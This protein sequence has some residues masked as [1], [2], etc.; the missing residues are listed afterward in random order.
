MAKREST[1]DDFLLFAMY[2]LR[3]TTFNSSE[4]LIDSRGSQWNQASALPCRLDGN[5]RHINTVAAL[6]ALQVT[7]FPNSGFCIGMAMHHADLD[8]QTTTRFQ[9]L[10]ATICRSG[11]SSLLPAECLPIYDRADEIKNKKV[12]FIFTVDSRARLD[13]PIPATYFSNCVTG[14][15]VTAETCKI[16]GEDGVAIAVESF[17][18]AI[19]G[20]DSG[21]MRGMKKASH[22]TEPEWL[23]GIAGSTRFGVYDIDF[24]WGRPTK[25]ETS[26]I[27]KTGS[28]SLAESRDGSKGVETSSHERRRLDAILQKIPTGHHLTVL[29]QL[30]IL[31]GHHQHLQQQQQDRQRRLQQEPR[32]RREMVQETTKVAPL[33]VPRVLRQARPPYQQPQNE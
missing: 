9:K 15:K 19:R 29:R 27:H 4:L 30:A 18:E 16:M 13:P 23:I 5:T 26:S 8:G 24:G 33:L 31:A 32:A 20:L 25:V 3:K 21:I 14:C 17:S 12:N 28:I 1:S 7:V 2:R 6:L 22:P 10:W 11:D